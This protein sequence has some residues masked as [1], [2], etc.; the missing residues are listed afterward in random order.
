MTG[1]HPTAGRTV[2]VTELFTPAAP[3]GMFEDTEFTSRSYLVPPGFRI[4]VH[5][6]GANEIALNDGSQLSL[7]LSWSPP[8]SAGLT[9]R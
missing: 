9:R 2:S 7:P 8:R 4:L 1:K 6:D 3:I 5:S